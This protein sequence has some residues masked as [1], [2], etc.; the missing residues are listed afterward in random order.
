MS[1]TVLSGRSLGDE[2]AANLFSLSYVPLL[3]AAGLLVYVLYK[4]AL[5]KPIP[6]VP[7]NEA[8]THSLLG[9]I[10]SLQEGMHR[11]GEF[12]LWLLEQADK[13]KSPLFQL[14]IRPLGKPMLVLTDFREAQDI[15]M[16]R[17]EF[18]RSFLTAD[19]LQGAGPKH[20]INMKTD[21]EWKQ[22][23]RLLQ[24]LMSP[25][26]L[27]EVAGPSVYSGV[28]RLVQLWND[29]ASIAD[30]R[31]FS[32]EQDIY[33]G[34]LDAVMAF[35]FG[36]SFSS[37]AIQP[38]LDLVKGLGEEDIKRLRCASS[39]GGDRPL[40]FPEGNCDEKITATLDVANSIGY[41][42]GS[43]MP[44]LKWW[45]VKR[46][47]AIRRAL[48]MKKMLVREEILKALKRLEEVGHEESRALSAVELIVL[49]EKKLAGNEGR[50]PDFFSM[51]MIDEVS[52]G[53]SA[54]ALGCVI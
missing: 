5:P 14:F 8:A 33:Y 1:D 15:L 24:D 29:K 39:T 11:T 26:F 22:H 17:K 36:G 37:S 21:G 27:N 49:R 45:F 48:E 19:L 42:Q 6:G 10:P 50:A 52:N 51:T 16:R 35:T 54:S 41:L 25:Q 23:R 4:W 7:H 43:P 13:F 40:D 47:P 32:A 12:S 3:V 34:A 44:R 53:L 18:D 30:G 31:P 38:T 28:L 46:M 2:K 20:H 9:D